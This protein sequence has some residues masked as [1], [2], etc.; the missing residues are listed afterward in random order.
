MNKLANAITGLIRDAREADGL[1]INHLHL[2]I[3]TF[4]THA[5]K[6]FINT[7]SNTLSIILPLEYFTHLNK[8]CFIILLYIYSSCIS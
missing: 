2:T 3:T 4:V 7:D 8:Y 6:P 5:I 1:I